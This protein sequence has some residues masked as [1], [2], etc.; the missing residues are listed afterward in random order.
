[1]AARLLAMYDVPA[2]PTAFEQYY[3]GT[4]LPLAKR[5]PGLRS[6]SINKGPIAAARGTSPYYL[7]ATLE[8]DSLEAM[9]AGMSAPEGRAASADVANFA[10]AGVTIVMFESTD[11]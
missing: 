9:Q 10:M 1:M 3:H 5:I 8:F 11:V 7:I 2:D 6:Y 4:H